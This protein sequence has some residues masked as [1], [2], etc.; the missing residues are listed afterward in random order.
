LQKAD[1]KLVFK[2]YKV[3]DIQFVGWPKELKCTKT[4]PNPLTIDNTL[5]EGRESTAQLL[6]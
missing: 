2:K 6:W 4:K 1:V 5:P 3:R